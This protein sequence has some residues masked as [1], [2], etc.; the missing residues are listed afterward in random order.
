MKNYKGFLIDIDGVLL[1]GDKPIAGAAEALKYLRTRG[2][3]Y[4]L[5]SGVTRFS[6]VEIVQ[7]LGGMGFELDENDV[8]NTFSND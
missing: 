7:R 8:A 6:K 5:V 2:L 3:P 1:E 4:V